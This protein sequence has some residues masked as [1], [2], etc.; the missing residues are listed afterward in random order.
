MESP[1][2]EW[3]VW[4]FSEAILGKKQIRV[5]FVSKWNNVEPLWVSK[6]KKATPM[7]VSKNQ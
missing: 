6:V 1:L 4:S 2:S 7:G 5:G 3:S